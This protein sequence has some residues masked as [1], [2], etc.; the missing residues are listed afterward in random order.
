MA[1]SGYLGYLE[2][3]L[4]ISGYLGLSLAI[5]GGLCQ[6]SSIRVPKEAGKSKLLKFETFPFF[7]VLPT[8]VIEELAL[9]KMACF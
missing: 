2:L 6:V 1:I 7:F 4:A 9:L 3:S 8:G 5:L